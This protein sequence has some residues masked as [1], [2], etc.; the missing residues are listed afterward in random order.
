MISKTMCVL[1]SE[2]YS[3]VNN[4]LAAERTLATVPFA[5]RYRLIDFVLSSLVKAGVNDIGILTKEHY[6]SLVDHLGAGKDW[7]LDRKNGG[8]KILTPFARADSAA[9]RSRS[10]TDA[11]L[12]C[13]TYLEKC[14]EE[15]VIL[16]DTNIVMNIDFY[17]LVKYHINKDADITVV[18]QKCSDAVYS[19]LVI[20]EDR[21]GRVIDAYYP[22]GQMNDCQN[23]VLKVFVFNKKLLL[24]L[25]DRAY[26]FGWTDFERDFITKNI[27]KLKICGYEHK[28][29]CAVINTVA[30]LYQ[31]SME[32]LTPARRKEVF[33]SDTTILTRVKN[34]PPTIYGFECKA[35]NSLI[36]DGCVIEGTIEDC[37]IF[38][39][40]RIEKGAVLKGCVI[41][42]NSV[43]HSGAKLECVITDKEVEIGADRELSGH[44][45]FP[46]VISKGA[47]V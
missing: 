6:G 26:T 46:Y 33:E 47:K 29:Y 24:S 11:L 16:A 38:R 36:A 34:S 12:S 40:V 21:D 7:D 37:V 5:G 27:N 28:G 2:S 44:P 18:Y 10:K 43:I 39:G 9:T 23:Q 25:L 17:D 15:Y 22:A 35:K 42:Q 32:M 4:E 13:R 1:F 3:A 41:G 20:D 8:L 45:T 30:D 31:A 19:G 14:N